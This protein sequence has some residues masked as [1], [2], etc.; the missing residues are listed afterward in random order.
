MSARDDLIQ[1]RFLLSEIEHLEEVIGEL[2]VQKKEIMQ[3]DLVDGSDVDF[4]YVKH[5]IR[6]RGLDFT[7][8]EAL[9]LNEQYESL[10]I[11]LRA[12]KLKCKKTYI[13]AMSYIYECSDIITRKA[14]EC[15][16]IDG[17]T[18]EKTAE[19]IGSYSPDAV[20]KMCTRYLGKV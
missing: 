15:H 2:E 10:I 11:R 13:R 18:W 8:E 14:L 19:C 20:R 3:S 17:M 6:I 12:E 7:T 1:Y 5:K 9:E 16:Y 4:P